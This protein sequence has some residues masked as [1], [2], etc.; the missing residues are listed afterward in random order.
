MKIKWYGTATLLIQSGG[1]RILFD[2]YLKR[3][4]KLPPVP[5]DEAATADAVFITHPHL[6]HFCDVDVFLEAGAG[7][8]YVSENGIARAAR[9][10]IDTSRMFPLRAGDGVRVGDM[11]VTAYQGRHCVF[12]AAT[13]LGVALNPLT[14]TKLSQGIRLL[15]Q[16]KKFKITDDIYVLY[17]TDGKQ[18][19]AVL[20]SAGMDEET[21][22]PTGADL[23]VFP[24]QGRARM[25]RYLEPFLERFRPKAVMIDHFDDAFPPL[26]KRVRT[27]KFIP[28]VMKKLPEATAIVPK[29]GVWYEV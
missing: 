14:Y 28:A 18:T 24:Y 27:E 16:T 29:E 4:P 1:T 3:N 2:P 7:A 21:Q 8:V 15:K 5:V 13:V 22:Y 25:H 6:D 11:T 26:S 20:G 17:V 23:L 10:G 9:E 19:A 12:D